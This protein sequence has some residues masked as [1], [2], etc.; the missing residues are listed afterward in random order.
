MRKLRSAGPLWTRCRPAACGPEAEIL[1]QGPKSRIGP[2]P[3]LGIG[4]RDQTSTRLVEHT[5][6]AGTIERKAGLLG[7]EFGEEIGEDP[8]FAR[9]EAARW[10]HGCD[11]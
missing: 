1:S 10:P 6:R 5:P 11:C 9:E 4:G 2:Q 7:E 3:T 8:D